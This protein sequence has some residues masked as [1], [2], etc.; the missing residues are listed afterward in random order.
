MEGGHYVATIIFFS[1][2][3]APVLQ[4]ATGY[5]KDLVLESKTFLLHK[6]NKHGKKGRGNNVIWQ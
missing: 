5:C 3:E 6:I 2:L 1:Q 4:I